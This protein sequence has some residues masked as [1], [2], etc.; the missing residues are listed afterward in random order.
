VTAAFLSNSARLAARPLTC[1]GT[2]T[3][4]WLNA[5]LDASPLDLSDCPEIVVAGA[6]PDDETLGF[7]ATASQLAAAG[8]RVQIVSA[9]DGGAAY[10]SQSVLQRYRLERTRRA[11]LHRAARVLGVAA[12]ICLGLP[13]GEIAG[14][15]QRLADLLT[16]ILAAKPP[17]TWCAATWRGDGHPD[18]EAVGRAAAVAAG[19]TGAVLVEYPVWMW[20]WARP[21]DDAVPWQRM[22]TAPVDVAATERKRLAAQSFRSQFLPPTHDDPPVLPPAVLHRLLA[23]GE[24]VFR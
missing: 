1:G 12:P 23:V 16:E 3:H 21:G 13:D 15:E 17:G 19:R 18:H 10:A 8:V 5:R 9:S 20:H 4:Q 7:G 6:H 14:H 2:P 24:V 22:S 11:E